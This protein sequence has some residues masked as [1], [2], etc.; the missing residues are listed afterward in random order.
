M[1]FVAC[2]R[3]VDLWTEQFWEHDIDIDWPLKSEKSFSSRDLVQMFVLF[4]EL[5]VQHQ[6]FSLK[7]DGESTSPW[8]KSLAADLHSGWPAAKK[9]VPINFIETKVAADISSSLQH[10]G[11]LELRNG[12]ALFLEEHVCGVAPIKIERLNHVLPSS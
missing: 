4:G 3:W 11:I 12:S 6:S 9:Y 8:F 2:L 7:T 10:S 5:R 1:D